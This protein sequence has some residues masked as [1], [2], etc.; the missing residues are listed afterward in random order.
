M[1]IKENIALALAGL[2][3]NK[4]RAF[5]TM[6]GII[7]GISS[8]IAITTMGTIVEKGL[9][10]LVSDM[11]VSNLVQIYM[12]LKDD[13]TRNWSDMRD[14]DRISEDMIQ[15]IRER[16][17]DEVELV[18][19]QEHLGQG[20]TRHNRET[21]NLNIQGINPE[22]IAVNSAEII[23]GRYI[24]QND[25]ERRSNVIVIPDKLAEKMYGS[26]EGA[27][28]EIMSVN[29]MGTHRDFAV[30]GVT[31]EKSS[32]FEGFASNVYYMLMPFTTAA[33]ISNSTGYFDYVMLTTYDGVDVLEFSE[34]L[35]AYVNERF[36]QNNDSFQVSHYSMVEELSSINSFLLILQAVLAVIAGISL[37]VGGIGVMNIMLVSVTERTREI[38]VR[39]ALG[40]PNTAIRVQFI[41]EAVI[42]C[43]I[44][45]LVGIALGVATGNAAGTIM[46]VAAMPSVMAI[47]VAVSFSMFIG[48][49]FGY[50]P[51]NR[52]AKLNPIEALR[53]E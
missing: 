53:Y 12:E 16:F 40:A 25:M 38:G 24:N 5:L 30:V 1:S 21:I 43:S 26:V 45:G 33:N 37:L 29:I 2:K 9:D 27:I 52:A 35:A 19:Y 3:A 20:N 34:R 44:G 31:R 23:R 13:N 7:I 41:V 39:K 10:G 8:V 32:M 42:I 51:A 22:S 11:G 17:S 47:T 14:S 49:F 50:Y 18:V 15:S 46:N 4:M 48:V 28:G 6:L 36:Y